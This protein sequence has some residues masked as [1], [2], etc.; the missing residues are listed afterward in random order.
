MKTIV[1][2]WVGSAVIA[3]IIGL[4]NRSTS[5]TAAQETIKVTCYCATDYDDAGDILRA[6][7]DQ[8]TPALAGLL[9]RGKAIELASGTKVHVVNRE[10]VEAILIESGFHSGERCYIWHKFVE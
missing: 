5:G 6:Y 2:I 10:D 1:W 3:V 8:D 9:M 7:H 4:A